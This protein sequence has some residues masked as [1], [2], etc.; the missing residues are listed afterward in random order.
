MKV[1]HTISGLQ[2]AA[3]TSVF[4]VELCDHLKLL[5]VEVT[6]AVSAESIE[7][8]ADETILICARHEPCLLMHGERTTAC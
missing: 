1:L 3:G 7:I 8:E 4:C 5:G 6:I 2:K